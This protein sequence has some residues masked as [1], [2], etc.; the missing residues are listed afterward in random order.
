MF[1]TNNSTRFDCCFVDKHLN[2][3]SLSAIATISS[4][5]ILDVFP[6]S[7]FC[8]NSFILPQ[9]SLGLEINHLVCEKDFFLRDPAKMAVDFNK[10]TGVLTLVPLS[11]KDFSSKYK[12]L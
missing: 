2:S 6:A 3:N 7:F 12:S 4:I 5:F 11:P 10:L 8:S 9:S 1:Y